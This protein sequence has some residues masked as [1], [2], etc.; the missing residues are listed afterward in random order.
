MTVKPFVL[1]ACLMTVAF[2]QAQTLQTIKLAPAVQ[3]Q[4]QAAQLDQEALARQKLEA[5]NRKL[6]AENERL[7]QENQALTTRV[8]NFSALG[9]SEVHA[10]CADNLTSRNSAGVES[11]CGLSGGYTCEQVSGL[12]HTSCQTSDMCAGG[13]T[14]D[15]GIQQCVNTS[16]G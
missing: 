11:N 16:G 10:Y 7:R 12:C 14:C 6:R 8:N 5:E 2:A 15:T 4:L 9:G 13:F 1:A 3:P